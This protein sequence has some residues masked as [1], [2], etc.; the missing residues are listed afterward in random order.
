M[1]LGA[2]QPRRAALCDAVRRRRCGNVAGTCGGADAALAA[3]RGVRLQRRRTRAA[4]RRPPD[5]A[6]QDPT[7][8]RS[9]H[10][11]RGRD[12]E[13]VPLPWGGDKPPYEFTTGD[14]SWL[15]MPDDW[16]ALTVAAQERD[17]ASTLS[18]Y[19]RALSLRAATPALQGDDFQWLEA[20]PDCLAYRRG[21]VQVLVNA[22]QSAGAA[23]VRSG[24]AHLRPDGRRPA[25]PRR[26]QLVAVGVVTARTGPTRSGTVWWGR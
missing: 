18:L 12:G 15:P 26:S 19:R 3:G 7:W 10:T 11:E 13:R 14:S 1:H 4:Q 5:W 16:A 24:A 23:S 17:A 6:L 22:C 25:A 21:N 20:P 9:G 2:G 8:E